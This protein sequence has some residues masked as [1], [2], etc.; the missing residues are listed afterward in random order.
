MT[1]IESESLPL[2][3]T[4][5]FSDESKKALNIEETLAPV[6]DEVKEEVVE[7]ESEQESSIYAEA[8]KEEETPQKK[9]TPVQET[10]VIEAPTLEEKN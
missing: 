1:T 2:E 5:D 3:N 10:E 6:T 7:K 8:P 4:A 9:E